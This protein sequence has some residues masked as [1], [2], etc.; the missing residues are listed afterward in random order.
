MTDPDPRAARRSL[1]GE[2]GAGLARSPFRVDRDRI[3]ASPFFARLAGVTQVVSQTGAG[4]LLHNRLTHSLQVA[5]V[6]RAIA[7]RLTADPATAVLLDRLGGCSPDVVEAAALAHDLGHPPFGHLGEQVL[8]RLGRERLGLPDGFEGN[9]QSFRIVTT[10]DLHGPGGTG[11]DLTAAVRAA[12]LKYPW[13]RRGHPDPH[14][15]AAAVPPRGAGPLPGAADAGSAKFSCYL[16]ELDDLR[17]GRAAFAGTVGPWQQTPEA[18]VMDTAD[19][20]AYAIHDLEDFHRVGVLQQPGVATELGGWLRDRTGLAAA[21]VSGLG[22]L[23]AG[24]ELERLRRRLRDKDGWAFDDDAF[25]AAVT[26]V[27][28]ELVDGLLAVPFDGSMAAERSVAEFSARWT[29]R[30]V[31][32]VRVLADP[33]VRSAPVALA[34][35]PWHEVAVL[36]FVHHRFVLQRADLASHQRGQATVLAGLVGAL[37]EWLVDDDE[38]VRLPP[39]LHDLVAL[40]HEEYRGLDGAALPGDGPAEVAVLARGR[41]VMDYVASLTDGQ[42]AAMLDV[43]TGRSGR[44]WT[45]AVVL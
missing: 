25:A 11:L 8:D 10:I 5:Q 2:S 43:L 22:P 24:A 28:E 41:A 39:R 34:A 23:R 35:G 17:A 4:L 20:I 31:G 30:L 37:A 16:T 36:K 6:A 13:A 33:P 21:P 1:A 45:D 29:A 7:E 14:P 9:A 40:A 3:A 42:A 18:A 32:G 12:L 38:P 27:C 26:V 15:S 19:D 44:L